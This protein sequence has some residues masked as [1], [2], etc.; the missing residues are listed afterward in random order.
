MY[1]NYVRLNCM[2][3]LRFYEPGPTVRAA[4]QQVILTILNK[5]TCIPVT[6]DSDHS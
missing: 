6:K 1:L 3:M 4:D 5:H 2:Q